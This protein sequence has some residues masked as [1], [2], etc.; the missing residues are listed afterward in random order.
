MLARGFCPTFLQPDVYNGIPIYRV[1]DRD[2]T[3]L[4][5]SQDPGLVSE[6][7]TARRVYIGKPPPPPPEGGDID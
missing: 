2:G 3:V 5:P 7:K 1:M 4:D 6:N